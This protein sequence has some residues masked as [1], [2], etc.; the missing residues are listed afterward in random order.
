MRLR[1][2]TELKRNT[3]LKSSRTE[4]TRTAAPK[5]KKRLKAVSDKRRAGAPARKAAVA[6]AFARDGWTLLLV[7]GEEHWSGGRCIPKDWGMPGACFG[8][9][10]PHR[11]QKGSYAG[12][13]TTANVVASCAH[14]N[15]MIE[16]EPD[17]AK[18][19]GLV[20]R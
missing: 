3:P 17:L 7:G 18:A 1:R 5:R 19:C 2:K 10:T 13:Y 6:A 11:L 14:H 8:P 4:L 12:G 20:H 16:D 15:S 9:L